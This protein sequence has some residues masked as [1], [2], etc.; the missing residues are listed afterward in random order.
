MTDKK[1]IQNLSDLANEIIEKQKN[2]DDT[3]GLAPLSVEE[4]EEVT[5]FP[6]V[7]TR[8][9]AIFPKMVAPLVIS[10]KI[11][12]EAFEKAISE[13]ANEIILV[14]QKNPST[15]SPHPQDLYSCGVL[16]KIIQVLKFPDGTIKAI[17]EGVC[18]VEVVNLQETET[19]YFAEIN[20]IEESED[21]DADLAVLTRMTIDKFENYVRKNSRMSSE[22]LI[23]VSTFSQEPG[24]LADLIATYLEIDPKEKQE[25]L[26]IAEASKRLQLMSVLL[27]REMERLNIEEGLSKKLRLNVSKNQREFYLREKM[28]VIKEELHEGEDLDS[29]IEDY[30]QKLETLDLPERSK[31]KILKE[32]KRMEKLPSYSSET[33]VVRTYLDR[34]FDLPW[35]E[36]TED[37]NDITYAQE[38]LDED[39]WGLEDVKE[40]ILEFLAVKQLTKKKHSTILCLLGP[41]GVGKTSLAKSV[42]RS[43]GRKF[44]YISLG[45]VNDE[46]E[47]RG[48]RRTYIGSMPG[49][50]IQAIE[51]AGTKNPVIV[52][53]EIEK[54]ARSHQGDPIAAMLEVLDPEQNEHFSDHYIDIP[55]DLSDTFFIATAN[56]LDNM[57]KALRDRLEVITLS[58]YTEEEKLNIAKHFLVKKQLDRHGLKKTNLTISDTAIRK[59]CKEYTRE[60]GVRNLERAIAKV[61][62]KVATRIVKG[63]TSKVSVTARNVQDFLGTPKYSEDEIRKGTEIGV[64]NGLAYTETGGQV[65]HIEANKMPGKG[66]LTLTGSLGDVMQESARAA[67]TYIRSHQE[68]L[69]IDD[70]F[71]EKHD[72]HIHVPDG[73]TPKDGP[74]AGLA[75]ALAILSVAT[76]KPLRSDVAMTGEI[77][78]RGKVL[79]IGG[80][81]EKVLAALRNNIYKVLIPARN[82]KDV[83]EMPDYVKDKV[84]FVFVDHLDQALKHVF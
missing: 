47:I 12:V 16:A 64:I 36:T 72:F 67:M 63:E 77:T 83:S 29:E 69:G 78:L 76:D 28:K 10:R 74:S 9:V 37:I 58:S 84:E 4:I 75:I 73:A 52:L 66:K 50:I 70:D 43:L 71:Q 25:V 31:K 41:P 54:M 49:R 26:E 79:P 65:L 34:I 61:C 17:V 42:A 11:S 62:R 82:K 32:I 56:S 81:K 5:V 55:F 57:Y 40:R 24:R 44:G 7:P 22:S 27:E 60:A 21:T 59:I 20:E 2:I 30:K 46:S 13:E 48:H 3:E 18:R 38:I 68:T 6:V 51:H 53:D 1:N 19:F 23:S 39:H 80:L 15:E 35:N 8:D 33:S 45:G 14:A